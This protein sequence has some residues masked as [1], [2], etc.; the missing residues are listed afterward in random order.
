MS[1]KVVKEI[2][3][4]TEEPVDQ[5]QETEVTEIAEEQPEEKKSGFFKRHWKKIA[6]IGAAITAVGGIMF[7]A[8]RK[9]HNDDM[10]DDGIDYETAL[11]D[12]ANS[13]AESIAEGSESAVEAL[14]ETTEG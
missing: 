13:L 3:E 4:V 12:Y 14:S 6:G 1:K 9:L 10:E 7:L 8:T 11:K 5:V 2:A